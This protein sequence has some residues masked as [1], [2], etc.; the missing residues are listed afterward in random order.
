MSFIEE[1]NKNKTLVE[2]VNVLKEKIKTVAENKGIEVT[3]G[4]D[5][6]D[7]VLDKI[8]ALEVGGGGLTLDAIVG[9][10]EVPNQEN[11]YMIFREDY[12]ISAVSNGQ[13]IEAGLTFFIENGKLMV[14][15]G[16]T[17]GE[18]KYNPNDC[19]LSLDGMTLHKLNPSGTLDITKNGTHFVA[20]YEEVNVSVKKNITQEG[21]NLILG[22]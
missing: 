13:I 6:M 2:Q 18:A 11:A 14:T 22:G 20:P 9:Y 21:T 8:D 4:V 12:T 5:T 10:W 1:I 16:E 3:L 19:T 17:T 15:E 7:T